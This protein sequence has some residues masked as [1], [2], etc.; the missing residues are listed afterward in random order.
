MWDKAEVQEKKQSEVKEELED[1]KRY[2][3]DNKIPN[4][5]K[6]KRHKTGKVEEISITDYIKGVLP[7]EMPP[8]SDI[9]A[10]KAQ[11]VVARTYLY[12][13]IISGGH[14]DADICD[15]PAHCQAYYS[16]DH[17]LS[18]WTSRGFDEKTKKEYLEKVIEAVNSTNNVV[19]TYNGEYI[20]AYFHANSGGKTEDVSSIWGKQKIPYL[21]SVESLGEESHRY[22]KTEV[23][24]SISELQSKINKSLA[25]PC[26]IS[27]SENEV[28]KILSYT[29][30]GR[31]DKVEIG[32]SIYSATDLRTTLGLKSTNFKVKKEGSDIV[33]SV[34]GY[35]HGIGMS[36]TGADYYAKQG[37][38]YDEIIQHYYKGVDITYVNGK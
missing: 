18:I 13:K 27:K 9:E 28:V 1:I 29:T 15:N 11:A 8:S 34:T 7:S 24:L 12:Q 35:G 25:I 26:K 36:Q 4:I 37:Y 17:I 5:I 38:T 19:A 14:A 33:F 31:I 32:G 20:K 16:I 23:K 10:L 22:Y 6:L 21:T 30:T 2:I 3:E